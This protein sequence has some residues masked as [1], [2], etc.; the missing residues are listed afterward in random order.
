LFISSMG[1]SSDHDKTK[2]LH[3]TTLHQLAFMIQFFESKGLEKVAKKLRKQLKKDYAQQEL[4]KSLTGEF[5]WVEYYDG[6]SE[7]E[8]ETPAKSEQETAPSKDS[9]ESAQ[10][11]LVEVVSEDEESKDGS[12]PSLPRRRKQPNR[13]GIQRSVSF[14]DDED[15]RIISP[16]KENKEKFFYSKDELRKFREEKAEEERQQRLEAQERQHKLEEERLKEET[17]EAAR[18]CRE[19]EER[20]RKERAEATRKAEEA[21]AKLEALIANAGASFGVNY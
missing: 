2:E 3:V 18:K 14:S 8:E 21:Q 6:S 12:E 13:R 5:E 11:C 19:D 15:V 9:K 7:E 10:T 17:R 4:P 20:R 16:K 1:E